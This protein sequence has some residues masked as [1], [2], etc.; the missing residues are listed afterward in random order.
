MAKWID[1][2]ELRERLD[3]A[4]VL[5]HYG[6]ELKL[7]KGHQHQG[8][9]PLPSH[10]GKRRSPSFSANLERNI[11]QCFGCQA[12]GNII[13]FAVRMEGRDPANPADVRSVAL[14]LDDVFGTSSLSDAKPAGASD[15]REAVPATTTPTPKPPNVL[16]NPPLDFELQHLNPNHPY[17]T[18]RGLR[19][20]TIRHFSLG[21]CARGLLKDRIA[22]PIRD[23]TG[24]LVGYAGRIVDDAKI[25]ESC[26][27]YLFP[28]PREKSGSR[29]EFHKSVL[30]YN[31]HVLA[32][33]ELDLVVVEGFPS[34]WHL[35]Q[36]GIP[37]V[38][39][40][41]GA[42]C[43]ERQAE[44]IAEKAARVWL[45]SDGDPAGE[46]CAESVWRFL[47]TRCHVR[48]VRLTSGKQPTD[49]TAEELKDLLSP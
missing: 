34:V 5:R 10:Q 29:I 36:A 19:P 35:H 30:V 41:M 17:L 20:E 24:T 33:E 23:H 27:K 7:K 22:I 2:K 40:L 32:G 37:N 12:R 21:F 13:D 43:S 18:E 31:L 25:G 1:F 6:V 14:K 28:G 44:L 4:A 38:V 45:M 47:G 3:F 26:P 15:A 8:F 16:V 48:W 49:C 39:A 9:C 42:T 46:H 11:W